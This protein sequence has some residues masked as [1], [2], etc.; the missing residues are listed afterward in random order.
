[1]KDRFIH[2]LSQS[3]NETQ[4]IENVPGIPPD[5]PPDD[6]IDIGA[7]LHEINPLLTRQQG[8]AM[9]S[10]RLPQMPQRRKRKH[11]IAEPIRPNNKNAVPGAN[12]QFRNVLL[13]INASDDKRVRGF[14]K[15]FR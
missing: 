8:Y 1:M 10:E 7:P 9:R 2:S 3:T 5:V 12:R 14:H 13:R 15:S 11:E 6:F 4:P